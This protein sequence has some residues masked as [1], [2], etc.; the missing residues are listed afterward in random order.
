MNSWN[1]MTYDGR[2]LSGETA[3]LLVP[4]MF[5]VWQ[6]TFSAQP[7]TSPTELGIRITSGPNA[8]DTRMQVSPEGLSYQPG[9]VDDLAT[10]IE[11]D[12]S[13]FVLT[14]YGRHN[15]GTVRGDADTAER[16]LSS[17][18]RI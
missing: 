3:D 15:S 11:F 14:T 18:F 5:V 13:S 12:P 2:G 1:A 7:Q 16:Y 10:V 9:K 17:F 4:F 8:G 6:A